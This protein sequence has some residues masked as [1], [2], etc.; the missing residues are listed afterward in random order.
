M[1][2]AFIS[3]PCQS[4]SELML[5]SLQQLPLHLPLLV[6]LSHSRQ[7]PTV[8]RGS[9]LTLLPVLLTVGTGTVEG[10]GI[11]IVMNTVFVFG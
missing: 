1:S 9:A 10:R 2:D 8:G 7:L 3:Y 5:L 6:G 11:G 4:L